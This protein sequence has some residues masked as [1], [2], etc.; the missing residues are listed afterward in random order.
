MLQCQHNDSNFILVTA[1]FLALLNE[2]YSFFFSG[3]L[4]LMSWESVFG[5]SYL[6]SAEM[7]QDYPGMSLL[8][9]SLL[10]KFAGPLPVVAVIASFLSFS[11]NVVWTADCLLSSINS[12]IWYWCVQNVVFR[13]WCF[14]SFS[15]NTLDWAVDNCTWS[16]FFLI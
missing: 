2:F 11:R 7:F 10:R 13:S 6:T 1:T 4:T 5:R 12:V 3:Q 8:E 14:S 9:Q 15:L 16:L